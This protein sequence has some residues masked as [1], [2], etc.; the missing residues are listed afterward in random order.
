MLLAM[1]FY[2]LNALFPPLPS[3]FRHSILPFRCYKQVAIKKPLILSS[4][5]ISEKFYD[6]A[7]APLQMLKILVSNRARYVPT[8]GLFF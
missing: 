8:W 4:C 6:S 5:K 7:N 1:I 3:I 2:N